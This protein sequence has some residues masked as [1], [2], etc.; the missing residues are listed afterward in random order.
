MK[1]Q[2]LVR[3]TVA[4]LVG[5]MSV[6]A[7]A[8][9]I[10]V[11]DRKELQEH[12]ETQQ[13]SGGSIFA[14]SPDYHITPVRNTITFV[15]SLELYDFLVAPEGDTVIDGVPDDQD[16]LLEV[17]G[18]SMAPLV[19]ISTKN[20]GVGFT[21]ENGH[22]KSHYLRKTS[23]GKSY[24]EFY[25]EMQYS[26]IGA[27]LYLIPKIR[28]FPN[29]IVPTLL[30]GAKSLKAEHE[31][32]QP[33]FVESVPSSGSFKYRYAVQRIHLGANLGIRVARR[34]TIIPWYDITTTELGDATSNDEGADK[35]STVE[36]KS[37]SSTETVSTDSNFANVFRLDQDLFWNTGRQTKFGLDFAVEIGRL[38]IHLGG[39]LGAL[40]SMTS[41]SDRIYDSNFYL[42]A[43]YSMKAR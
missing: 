21:A 32:N 24:Q 39:I 27:F 34:F 35:I 40:G 37:G 43:S 25:G 17:N 3:S 23:T 1:G 30:V 41:G 20:F 33:R 9:P 18:W 10:P 12:Y 7:W 16:H 4:L 8:A 36:S 26:G 42:S 6:V 15:G 19:T 2:R 31:Q 29:W 11:P 13:S 5:L 38:E 22:R 28:K 14:G